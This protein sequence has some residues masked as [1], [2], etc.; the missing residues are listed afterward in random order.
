MWYRRAEL[1]PPEVLLERSR[2]VVRA[3]GANIGADWSTIYDDS[4]ARVWRA[5]MYFLYRQSPLPLI[6]RRADGR[7]VANDPPLTTRTMADVLLD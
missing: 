1:K 3:A 4:N 7:V 5:T 6:P 2:D